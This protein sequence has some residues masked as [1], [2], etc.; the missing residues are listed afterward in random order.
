[1]TRQFIPLLPAINGG[2]P[3]TV[4]ISQ[5]TGYAFYRDSTGSCAYSKTT[6]GGITWGS[7]VTIPTVGGDCIRV[8]VWYDR[9]TPGDTTGNLIHIA[10]IDTGDDDIWYAQLNTLNDSLS[11]PVNITSGRGYGGTLAAGTNHVTITKG[12]DGAL[13]A[14]V[15]DGSDNIMVRCTTNCTN[16]ANWS[17]SEPASWAAGNDFT[18][19]VPMLSGRVMLLWWDISLTTNDIRYSVWNGTSWSAFGNIDTALENTTYDASWGAAVDPSTGDVYLAYAAQANTLGTDD[20]IRVRRYNF[21]SGTWSALTDVVTN[22]VCAGSSNCGITGVKI[23]RDNTT[24]ILYVLYTA[25]STAGTASTGNLYWKYS[26]DGGSTWSQEFGPV[27]SSND[28]I[29]GGRL[30]LTPA[31]MIV[32]TWYAAGPDDLFSRQIAPKTFNQSAYRFFDNTDSTDVGSPLAAQNTAVT[33]SSAGSAFRLRMLLHV[34]IADLFT[35]EGDFKLQFAQRGADNLCDT[36]FTGETYQDITAST[37][38]AFNDNSTPADGSALTA[39]ANDPIHGTDT[40]RNQTYEELNNFTNSVSSI[41]AGE[42]GKWDFSLKDNGAPPNTTYC[43]RVVKADGTLL[44]T[45]S[46]IPQITTAAAPT[47]TCSFSATSTSFSNLSPSAV[48]V[49]SPDITVT[50]TSSAGFTISVKDQGNTTTPGLYNS[51][52][53]YL[54]PSPNSV[55]SATATLVAGIDGY[56]IQATTTNPNISINPRYNVTGNTVGGFTTTTITLA[57]STVSV[58]SAPITITHKVA[59]SS[60]APTGNYQDIITYSCTSP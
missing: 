57:S 12:T 21:S 8:A 5:T 55:F 53:N 10:M 27:Y 39:N 7:A 54:I 14:A 6:D 40:I 29:Y 58:S 26:T 36:S 41:N 24:G 49:S 19:L 28:D 16:A 60:L 11:T 35:N 52:S 17:V 48:S 47:I 9:W 25:Q 46:V 23:A 50:V 45:Y 3:T 32:A 44:E 2:S 18:I 31:Q 51:A 59:V 34:N 22:S 42:D 30:S 1:M 38:I 20:D 13:Y 43:F 33:L 56:G 15:T 4:F 37:V